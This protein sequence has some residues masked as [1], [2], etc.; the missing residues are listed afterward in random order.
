MSDS[1]TTTTNDSPIKIRDASLSSSRG[2]H[3]GGYRP[4]KNL[5]QQIG[6]LEGEINKDNEVDLKVSD[7]KEDNNDGAILAG[8]IEKVEIADDNVVMYQKSDEDD[9]SSDSSGVDLTLERDPKRCDFCGDLTH[10]SRYCSVL[11]QRSEVGGSG[12]GGGSNPPSIGGVRTCFHCFEEGHIRVDCPKRK[13]TTCFY[14]NK[15]GHLRADCPK[16]AN[17]ETKK[18]ERVTYTFRKPSSKKEEKDDT[19]PPIKDVYEIPSSGC[20]DNSDIKS[21]KGEEKSQHHI[22]VPLPVPASQVRAPVM[23][24]SKLLS[25]DS[26]PSISHKI[27]RSESSEEEDDMESCHESDDNGENDGEGGTNILNKENSLEE[28]KKKVLDIQSRI[29]LQPAIVN[30]KNENNLGEE[31][32]LQTISVEVDGCVEFDTDD[33]SSYHDCS[34]GEDNENRL[35]RIMEE[36]ECY[37]EDGALI[38]EGLD[39]NNCIE[40]KKEEDKVE[41]GKGKV[42]VEEEEE[43]EDSSTM[44]SEVMTEIEN[45]DKEQQKT[46]T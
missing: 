4:K 10:K 35:K 42:T 43:I 21:I 9:E 27:L 29:T 34:E 12:G 28:T 8:E 44:T 45:E 13:V 19:S 36:D 7:I 18:R 33:D 25:S 22:F 32:E 15:Q 6:L 46:L 30:D 5:Q 23:L 31:D 17:L 24:R 26:E 3:K 40:E 38:D 11:G 2:G 41:G 39:S 16:R 1:S 14:C 37:G 20:E